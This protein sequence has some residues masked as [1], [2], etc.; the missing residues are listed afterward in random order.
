M[1]KIF[2]KIIRLESNFLNAVFNYLLS[3]LS[4]KRAYLS[5]KISHASLS[6]VAVYKLIN[7]IIADAYLRCFKTVL[8]FL[9]FNKMFLCNMELLLP[10]IARQLYDLHTVEKRCLNSIESICSCNKQ[11]IT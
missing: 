1:A 11:H 9:L 5:F 7:S 4:A 10:S 6:C 8:T 2:F 3:S